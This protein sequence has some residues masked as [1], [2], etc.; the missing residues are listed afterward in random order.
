[1]LLNL[2]RKTARAT[3]HTEGCRTVPEPLGTPY[4][5]VGGMG[6]DGG[7]FTVPSHQGAV[8]LV[9]RYLPKATVMRCPRC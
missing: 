4:K 6:R 9:T 7:W 8:G 3:L 2:D 1:M 5:S